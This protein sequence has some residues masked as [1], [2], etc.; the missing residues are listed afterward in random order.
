[1]KRQ[2]SAL[3]GTIALAAVL[4]MVGI[5]L[6]AIGILI[7]VTGSREPLDSTALSTP[8]QIALVGLCLTSAMAVL[9]FAL[10]SYMILR[11]ARRLGPGYA[12]ATRLMETMRFR[13]AI[14]L[15]ETTINQGHESAEALSMLT[16]AYAFSGEYA[17]AQATADRTLRTY[18]AD[19]NSYVTL[20]L[21]YRM[22]GSYEEAAT[23][24]RRALELAPELPD[25]WAELG[26]VEKLAGNDEGAIHAFRT[27][28]SHAMSARYGVRVY[29]HLSQTYRKA[30]D[31]DAAIM[32]TAK[33]MSA[34]DGLALW[35]PMAFATRSSAYGQALQYEITAI[36]QAIADADA[37]NLG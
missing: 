19:P 8:V 24:L 32:A 9:G 27:A 26:F 37:G 20:A 23:T 31:V 30:G 18:P 14:P 35:K 13:S 15:L 4:A 3:L 1:V 17:K 34:R 11:Q 16:M 28:S 10:A 7:E 12:D 22:Q 6:F 36:E 5:G 33:M 25:L 29:Y 21:G 2:G